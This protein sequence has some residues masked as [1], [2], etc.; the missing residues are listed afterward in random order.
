MRP[1]HPAAAVGLALALA[2]TTLAL[3]ACRGGSG[4]AFVLSYDDAVSL[5]IP[6]PAGWTTE[7]A[8]QDGQWYRYFLPPAAPGAARGTGL[9]V[10][11]FVGPL[12]GRTLGN[13]A[14]TYLEGGTPESERETTRAGL[15]GREYR[16]GDADGRTAHALLLLEAG[17]RLYGLHARGPR[18]DLDA[19][20]PTL[21]RMR[22]GLRVERA[23]DWPLRREA[24]HGFA[25]RVPES[26]PEARRFAGND[27][28]LI[29][30]SSPLM[31]MD[32]GGQPVHASFSVTVE[33]LSAGVADADAFYNDVRMKLG[34]S[35]AVVSH[36]P[37]Q[38]GFVDVMKS[39][40]T[41]SGVRVKRYYRVRDGRGYVLSYEAREDVFHRYARWFDRIAGSFELGPAAAR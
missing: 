27:R 39:E 25:L 30:H 4:A 6:Y 13:Y 14:S 19:F 12:A 10:T 16:Y 20:D 34:D 35:Y 15:A 11:L 32:A 33:K 17:D 9:S 1:A 21:E 41:L 24:G 38:D 31:A 5:S 28:L 8:T 3:P 22:A 18:A 26:W 37:W 23:E 7:Q 40:T 2:G 29:V 36:A